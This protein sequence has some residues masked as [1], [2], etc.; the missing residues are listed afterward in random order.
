MVNINDRHQWVLSNS[1]GS[2]TVGLNE[3]GL[4]TFGEIYGFEPFHTS[5]QA[6]FPHHIQQ[7]GIRVK[8]C[9][10]LCVVS[11]EHGDWFIISP[12]TGL[13]SGFNWPA[14]FKYPSP[15]NHNPYGTWIVKVKPIPL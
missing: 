15:I 7:T 3:F 12:I 1:D 13:I 10:P 6:P 9:D 2:L 11:S 4:T 14:A 8:T 5:N